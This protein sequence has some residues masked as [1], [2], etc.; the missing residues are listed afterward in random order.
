MCAVLSNNVCI[1]RDRRWFGDGD[2]AERS[3]AVVYVGYNRRVST[4]CQ[5][6]DGLPGASAAPTDRVRAAIAACW[7]NDDTATFEPAQLT[8][9]TS[10]GVM[11]MA[12]GLA[13][14]ADAVAEQPLWSVTVAA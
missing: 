8:F 7:V 10:I 9:V 14:V 5:G 6:A 3:R 12:A 4:A 11:L 1:E 13:M 2:R